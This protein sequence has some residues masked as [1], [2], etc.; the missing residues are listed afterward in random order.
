[1]HSTGNAAV[2]QGSSNTRRNND[3]LHEDN[4][5]ALA[6]QN[7]ELKQ[8]RLLRRPL[9]QIDKPVMRSVASFDAAELL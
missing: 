5:R 8:L 4:Q 3:L 2:G 9:I 1:M 6:R 7:T